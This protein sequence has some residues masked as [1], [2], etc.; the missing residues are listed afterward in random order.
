MK[1]YNCQF[2][3]LESSCHTKI[4]LKFSNLKFK[5][6]KLKLHEETTN[7][8]VVDFEKLC[9]F[10]VDNIFIYI[11]LVSHVIDLLSIC[12]NTWGMKT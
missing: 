8:K 7:M 3:D 1:L 5:F 2:F 11:N 10:I 9:N 4:C 12:C 6:C